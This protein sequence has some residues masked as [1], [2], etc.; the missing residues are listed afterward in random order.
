MQGETETSPLAVQRPG[1]LEGLSTL[2]PLRS[3]EVMDPG[4]LPLPNRVTFGKVMLQSEIA[5]RIHFSMAF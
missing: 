2:C 1:M 5:L 3:R 4:T